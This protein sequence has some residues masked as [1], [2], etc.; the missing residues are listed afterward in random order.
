MKCWGSE[1]PHEIVEKPLNVEKYTA[2]CAMSTHGIICP[3]F[4]EEP[5]IGNGFRM[6]STSFGPHCY[7]VLRTEGVDSGF[8]MMAQH[9]THQNKL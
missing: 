9:P 8:S 2:W 5:E 7:A 6:S 1:N 3:Y 4:F